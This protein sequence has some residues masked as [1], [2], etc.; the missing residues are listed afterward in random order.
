MPDQPPARAV[1]AAILASIQSPCRSKRGVVIF[2][3]DDLIASG[4]NRPPMGFACDGSETCKA[5]CRRTA[6]HAEQLAL[7]RAG[8]HATFSEV[9]HVKT[10]HGALVPSGPPS[11]LECSKLMLEAAVSGVWLYHE[12]GWRR[13]AAN[14]FHRLTLQESHAL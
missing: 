1:D 2:H 10:V 14:E 6:V 11:C 12:D 3:G 8:R 13:Y 5:T 9:L 4:I 7:L